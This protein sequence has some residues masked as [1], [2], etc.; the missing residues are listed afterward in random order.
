MRQGSRDVKTSR[1]ILE[2]YD[3][4]GNYRAAA[5]LAGCDHQAPQAAAPA[6]RVV[7]TQRASYRLAQVTSGQGVMPPR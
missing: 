6:P 3:L 4:T 2:A 7:V 5:T 1:E